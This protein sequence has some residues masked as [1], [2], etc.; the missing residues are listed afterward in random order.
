LYK[1]SFAVSGL[2]LFLIIGTGSMSPGAQTPGDEQWLSFMEWNSGNPRLPEDDSMG[3]LADL[4]SPD[5]LWAGAVSVCDK[6]FTS[7]RRGEV[8]ESQFHPALKDLL[9]LEFHRALG[10][11]GKDV[12]PRYALPL[13]TDN[14][15]TVP[16][17]LNSDGI[18]SNGH[19]Y[20]SRWEGVWYIEQWSIDLT[21]FPDIS[22]PG[23]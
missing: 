13:R 17:R 16:L 19:I 7:I 23:N 6:A 21:V 2:F 22:P 12:F 10:S 18:T 4:R 15:V 20:L 1:Y 14:R 9:S 5:P 8:P 11:G 3:L